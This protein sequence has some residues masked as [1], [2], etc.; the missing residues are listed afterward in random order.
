MWKRNEKIL[1]IRWNVE[2]VVS[3]SETRVL[4][5]ETS[6]YTPMKIK[7]AYY[8]LSYTMCLLLVFVPTFVNFFYFLVQIGVVV[9]V[10][11]G[12]IMYRI[13]IAALIRV[14]QIQYITLHSLLIESVT[15]ALLQLFFI[16]IYARV[17]AT[18]KIELSKTGSCSF[19]HQC[20]CG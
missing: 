8:C 4:F 5:N 18:F 3:K 19:T 10:V 15:T 2:H 12:V 11:F 20:Q 13:S 6:E 17:F 7:A 16:K 1:K 14:S 9:L